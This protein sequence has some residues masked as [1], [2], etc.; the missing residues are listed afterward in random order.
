MSSLNE[1]PSPEDGY[2]PTEAR[3]D[4]LLRDFFRAETPAS[5]PATPLEAPDDWTSF[6]PSEYHPAARG[7]K[8]DFAAPALLASVAVLLVVGLWM[9]PR[10]DTTK[11]LTGKSSPSPEN[12]PPPVPAMWTPDVVGLPKAPTQVNSRSQWQ[13]VKDGKLAV[14]ITDGDSLIDVK[15]YSTSIGTIEQRTNVEWTTLRVY[16]PESG[17]WLQ[18]TVPTVRVEVVPIG[19]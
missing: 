6:A 1:A 4:S 5:L 10:T 19:Q 15:Y 9:L 17:E 7:S 8:W 14:T 3:I 13:N 12:V 2:D 18:A 11:Q 16:E